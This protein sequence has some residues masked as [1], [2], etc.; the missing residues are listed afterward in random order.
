MKVTWNKI[1]NA[2]YKYYQLIMTADERLKRIWMKTKS[3]G[4]NKDLN[5]FDSNTCTNHDWDRPRARKLKCRLPRKQSNCVTVCVCVSKNLLK[6]HLHGEAWKLFKSS[7]TICA[8]FGFCWITKGQIDLLP[9]RDNCPVC[10][11]FSPCYASVSII[12]EKA[13]MRRPGRV[14]RPAENDSRSGWSEVLHGLY[15][16]N[17]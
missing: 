7:L 5:I 2:F 14:D 17:S 3:T 16:S 6:M 9:N 4:S 10:F 8:Y 11:S 13:L 1:N 12:T 15:G